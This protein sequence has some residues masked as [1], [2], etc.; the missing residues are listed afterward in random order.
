MVGLTTDGAPSMVGRDKCLVGLCR[1]DEVFSHFSD[2]TALSVNK[3][4]VDIFYNY[5]VMKLVVKN[6]N[7]IR[8]QALQRRL[9]KTL[10][11]QYGALLLQSEVRWL[12]MGRVLKRFNDIIYA[13]VQFF[14]QRYELI[15]ELENSI[16]LRDFSFLVDITEK[17][18]ELNLHIQE[19]GKELSEIISDI[20]AFM[21]NL[22]FWEQNLI[23][24]D[25]RHFPVPPEKISQSPLEPYDRKY[26]VEI[27]SNLKD[28][29]KN[30][31]KVFNE[32]A[33]M[34]QFVSWKLISNTLQLLLRR[35]LAKT[36]LRQ[37]WKLMRFKM[38]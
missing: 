10:D 13:I 5:N 30:R 12:S 38:I 37:K 33:L 27:V 23:N 24:G 22:E 3:H 20:K 1:T 6:A 25:T 26:H 2:T 29:F 15:P 9:F 18:N 4:H 11:C 35:T 31:F 32:I 19:R 34:A 17:L 7:N 14:K 8:A 16:W 28:N 36:S 21:K